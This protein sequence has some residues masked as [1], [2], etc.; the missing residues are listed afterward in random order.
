MR[1][2]IDKNINSAIAVWIS[3]V[4]IQSGFFKFTNAPET[5]YIF[6]TVGQ[7]M[8]HSI[9]LALGNLMAQY[10][11]YFIGSVEYVASILLLIPVFHRVFKKKSSCDHFKTFVGAFLAFGVI[12]GALF[13]H[14]FTPLGIEIQGDGGTLFAMAVSV[15]I[16]SFRLLWKNKKI[17]HKC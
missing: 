6:N 1:Y 12:G 15:W 13:F 3:F 16:G 14:L 7:W 2:L 8:S 9:N 11:G 17:F 5:Q 4:F 10:G